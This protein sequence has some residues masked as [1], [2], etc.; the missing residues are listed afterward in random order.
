MQG[1][2]VLNVSMIS[3]YLY[4]KVS[5]ETRIKIPGTFNDQLFDPTPALTIL[6]ANHLDIDVALLSLY[7][8][9]GTHF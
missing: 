7:Y 6:T 4:T 2:N 5:S 9:Y 1:L 8:N 3:R